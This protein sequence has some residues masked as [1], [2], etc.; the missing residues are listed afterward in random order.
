[1][2]KIVGSGSIS[3]RHGSA[4]PDRIR[5]HTKISLDFSIFRNVLLDHVLRAKVAD[6]GLTL[7]L[8]EEREEGGEGRPV[9]ALYWSAPEAVGQSAP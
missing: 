6:F 2:T 1:M 4:D 5:I 3:Q 7:D 8:E 9:I